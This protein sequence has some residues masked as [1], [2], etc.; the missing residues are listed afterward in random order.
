M[1]SGK[2]TGHRNVSQEMLIHPFPITA[3]ANQPISKWVG[4]FTPGTNCKLAAVFFVAEPMRN[5]YALDA[6]DAC[7]GGL[8]LGEQACKVLLLFG[9]ELEKPGPNLWPRLQPG[10]VNKDTDAVSCFFVVK[11]ESITPCVDLRADLIYSK[12][13]RLQSSEITHE[14]SSIAKALNKGQVLLDIDVD[15]R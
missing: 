9:L 13:I 8:G 6:A 5:P 10:R 11:C 1:I 15:K 3:K 7:P 14:M 12:A 2:L 4:F